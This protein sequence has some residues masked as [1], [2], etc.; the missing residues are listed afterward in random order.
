MSSIIDFISDN[1]SIIISIIVVISLI[2]SFFSQKED[3]DK[4]KTES[5]T[6]ASEKDNSRK[7]KYRSKN[8]QTNQSRSTQRNIDTVYPIRSKKR[9][10]DKSP[11][12]N[13]RVQQ[14]NSQ[15]LMPS[16]TQMTYQ[17]TFQS[18]IPKQQSLHSHQ[19]QSDLQEQ[20]LEVEQMLETKSSLLGELNQEQR[21]QRFREA[22][23]MKEIIDS[24]KAIKKMNK[25]K[26]IR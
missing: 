26:Y 9:S 20:K 19:V 12:R 3:E 4:Q 18:S 15:R 17:D 1:F 25:I 21:R 11:R 23:I 24:P 13:Q 2:Q 14:L 10:K 8:T 6:S 22:I 16:G 5:Q 7:K